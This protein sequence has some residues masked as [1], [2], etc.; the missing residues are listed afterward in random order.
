MKDFV[1]KRVAFNVGGVRFETNISTLQ[2][3]PNTRLSSV[4]KLEQFYD[5]DKDE[6]FFDRNPTIFS[7]VLD[8]CRSGHLHLPSNLCGIHA[9]KELEFWGIPL[10]Y[11]DVCCWKT[12][13]SSNN[14]LELVA[15]LDKQFSCIEKEDSS[16]KIIPRIRRLVWR[17]FENPHSSRL[18]MRPIW[19]LVL[20]IY[21]HGFS[22]N[23]YI[24]FGYV[25]KL[26]GSKTQTAFIKTQVT[27]IWTVDIIC[28][29]IFAFDFLM[30][31][32]SCPCQSTFWMDI[33]NLADFGS[34]C[35]F[36]LICIMTNLHRITSCVQCYNGRAVMYTLTGAH[37]MLACRNLRFFRICRVNKSLKI[38]F[39]SIDRSKKDIALLSLVLIIMSVVFGGLVYYAEIQEEAKFEY[40][41]VCFY[42]AFTTMI[43][44]GY[45]DVVPQTDSGNVIA[46]VCGLIGILALSM[47]IAVISG[48]FGE[49][50]ARYLDREKHAKEKDT[51]E[52]NM[53]L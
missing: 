34:L 23:H 15:F 16:G 49:L 8:L 17:F 26:K 48:N 35:G 46:A 29:I 19:N 5:A 39:L 37:L 31:V 18:A 9:R 32:G 51:I 22:I 11:L 4:E 50:Y 40:F 43:M 1:G 7:S 12:F 24:S 10:R 41:H 20:D 28:N 21:D 27:W 45:G 44:G 53:E 14:D 6:F 38:L 2:S 25:R 30:R 47:L 52:Y 42:W 36:L 33:L 3:I 13:Y